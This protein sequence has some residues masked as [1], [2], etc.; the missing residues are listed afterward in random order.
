M[1]GMEKYFLTAHATENRA[2]KSNKQCG[3]S[4]VRAKTSG[5]INHA[6]AN[7]DTATASEL[8]SQVETYM[9]NIADAAT[10]N[11]E[12]LGALVAKTERLTTTNAQQHSTID[13]LHADIS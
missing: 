3:V 13:S 4:F 10:T 12:T 5:I 6:P 9:E 11:H 1:G 8:L 7:S 2:N